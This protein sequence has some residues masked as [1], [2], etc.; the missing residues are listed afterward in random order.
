M[1]FNYLSDKGAIAYDAKAARFRVVPSKIKEA[2]RD[3]THDLL[4]LE[5]EGN[6]QGTKEMLSRLG[7]IRAPMQQALDR[8][9]GIPIDILPTFPVA[10]ETIRGE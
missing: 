4:T 8:L 3:L 10:K 9:K 1:Q 7:V 6:Y 2:V 5:A